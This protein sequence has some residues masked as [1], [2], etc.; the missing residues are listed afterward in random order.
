MLATK[1]LTASG[2][3]IHATSTALR[4]TVLLLCRQCS[5]E[6]QVFVAKWG[7]GR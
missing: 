3:S 2:Q 1:E 5:V 6:S 4:V 7:E